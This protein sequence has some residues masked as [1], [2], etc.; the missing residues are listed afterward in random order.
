MDIAS[1]LSS[2]AI[3]SNCA[4][5]SRKQALHEVAKQAA[6]ITGLSEREVLNAL[7]ERER[8][9]STGMGNGIAIPHARFGK[10]TQL[11]ALFVQLQSPVA[12]D[13]PDG[14][15]VDL[16]FV[17]LAPAENNSDHLRAM[18]RV[19]RLLRDSH[20]CGKIRQAVTAGVIYHL[21]TADDEE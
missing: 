8:L 10:L 3:L 17:L 20:S 1:F 16:L 9:G 2:D 7:M 15:P 6:N 18:A 4:A 21:L 5:T 13:A 11:K 12:F 14:K 19:S